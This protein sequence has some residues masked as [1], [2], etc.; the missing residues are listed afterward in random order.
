MST[1]A[2][3]N[4]QYF[5]IER[6]GP[7]SFT[8]LS[9]SGSYTRCSNEILTGKLLKEAPNNQLGLSFEGLNQQF[10][11]TFEFLSAVLSPRSILVLLCLLAIK[12]TGS[13][14]W[15]SSALLIV[16]NL[17]ETAPL[18]QHYPLYKHHIYIFCMMHLCASQFNVN[19]SPQAVH[20][21]QCKN[22][23]VLTFRCTYNQIFAFVV[24]SFIPQYQ[25]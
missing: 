21:H 8:Q 25:V 5:W 19:P 18:Y 23:F 14:T 6:G 4:G 11:S 7:R 16:V 17:Y 24:R 10:L 3:S 9:T 22:L 12:Y 2:Q 1:P 15:S 13:A 20:P